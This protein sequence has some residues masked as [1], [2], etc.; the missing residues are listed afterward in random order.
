MGSYVSFGESSRS[1][2]SERALS[3]K[4]N[5][6]ALGIL[7]LVLYFVAVAHCPV[8]ATAPVSSLVFENRVPCSE[9]CGSF[10][11]ARPVIGHAMP[12]ECLAAPAERIDRGVIGDERARRRVN[13]CREYS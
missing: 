6:P 11:A 8:N 3:I 9:P 13:P 12:R 7:H 2:A 5:C 4:A 10:A 1:G